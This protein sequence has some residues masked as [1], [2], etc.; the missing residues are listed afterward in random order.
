MQEESVIYFTLNKLIKRILIS[1]LK[2]NK[3]YFDSVR[4]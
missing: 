4:H 1:G 3:N 2:A